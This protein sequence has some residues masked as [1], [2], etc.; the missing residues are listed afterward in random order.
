MMPNHEASLA[1]CSPHGDQEYINAENNLATASYLW[2]HFVC[3]F[4]WPIH[5]AAVSTRAQ[6][7]NGRAAL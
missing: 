3:N 7:L 4:H 2:I 1:I 5:T 6:S